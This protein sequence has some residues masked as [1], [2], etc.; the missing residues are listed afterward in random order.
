MSFFSTEFKL[1]FLKLTVL[2]IRRLPFQ[3]GPQTAELN[4]LEGH[5]RVS[6]NVLGAKS[7]QES[8][9]FAPSTTTPTSALSELNEYSFKPPSSL[10]KQ[11]SDFSLSKIDERHVTVEM[12]PSPGPSSFTAVSPPLSFVHSSPASALT[13]PLRSPPIPSP[14]MT[15]PPPPSPAQTGLVSALPLEA[16]RKASTSSSL[17]SKALDFENGPVGL[18]FS[19]S[20]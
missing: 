14:P 3:V 13:M 16:P 17:G 8:S 20:L 10:V 4:A 6:S 9:L 5:R 1:V 12:V 15:A 2:L 19:R 7:A 18:S 11:N